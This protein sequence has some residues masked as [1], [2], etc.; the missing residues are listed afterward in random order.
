[1]PQENAACRN[2]GRPAGFRSSNAAERHKYAILLHLQNDRSR[3]WGMAHTKA[4]GKVRSLVRRH[5]GEYAMNLKELT[6]AGAVALVG[7]GSVAATLDFTEIG[8]TGIV[9]STVLDL[10]NATLTS[11]GD[12]FFVSTPGSFGEANGLGIVCA[13]P[14]GSFNCQEDMQIDFDDAIEN[15]SFA[16]FGAASTGDLVEVTAFLDGAE[17][18]STVVTTN[19]VIDFAAFGAIDSLYFADSSS[20]AGIGFGDFSF[21]VI[22]PVPLPASAALL[23]GGLGLL[24]W[25]RKR[26][27]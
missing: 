8:L 22:A 11:L 5:I 18:G 3:C 27:A 2:V 21:D 12:D 25:R 4:S 14:V 26:A 1:M 7:T 15:L 16:S 20:Q 13:S 17:V 19:T 23:A 6:L 24:A 9:P 10:S